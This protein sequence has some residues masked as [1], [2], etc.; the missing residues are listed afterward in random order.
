MMA[1]GAT[2]IV[3]PENL[4]MFPVKLL[5]LV[6]AHPINFFFWVPT[7]MVNIANLD[8]LAQIRLDR[9][10]KVFFIGEV[11]PTKHLNYRR[12][13]LPKAMFVNL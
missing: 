1:K 6:A 4:A 2:M 5:E 11:F 7:I 3:V 8:L 12:R 13:H 9:L 10:T